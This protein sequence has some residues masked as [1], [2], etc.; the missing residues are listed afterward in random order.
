MLVSKAGV[1]GAAD[2]AIGIQLF[3]N[4]QGLAM[5]AVMAVLIGILP[6]MPMIP[7]FGLA[8]AAGYAAWRGFGQAAGR[9]QRKSP[10]PHRPSAP[11]RSPNRRSRD[12]LSVDDIKIELGFG[13]LGFIN[14]TSGRKLTDQVKAVR[15]Q[16][17]ADIRFR[18]PAGPDHRQ[19]RT[20]SGKTTGILIKEVVAGKGKLRPQFHLAMDASGTAPAIPGERVNEPVFGLPAVWVDDLGKVECR[21]P[22]LHDRGCRH[23]SYHPLHRI[24]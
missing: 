24:W 5:A 8:G 11:S 17:A 18:R 2:K 3:T 15:R 9:R 13:L 19:S 20:G 7:F 21:A 1:D 12:L 22:G 4:P 16:I 14:E 10:R 23:R 6:G